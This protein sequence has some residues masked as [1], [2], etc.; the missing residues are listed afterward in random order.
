[1]K[2]N[3]ENIIR[4]LSSLNLVESY[5]IEDS[6]DDSISCKIVEDPDRSFISDAPSP[7]KAFNYNKKFVKE[8]SNSSIIC[9]DDSTDSTDTS[10]ID[11]LN[12]ADENSR[13]NLPIIPI[14]SEIHIIDLVDSPSTCSSS[15]TQPKDSNSSIKNQQESKQLVFEENIDDQSLWK[16]DP[17]KEIYF[18][19]NRYCQ[20]PKELISPEIVIPVQLYDKLYDHQKVGIQWMASLHAKGIGGIL[21]DDMGLG[22]TMQT[23]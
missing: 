15:F 16:L 11:S 14:S 9:L 7:I 8:S 23:L 18:L 2:G 13:E 17:R 19:K 3:E 4:K 6:S 20:L 10:I 1:M 21:G 12:N 5:N 22:K